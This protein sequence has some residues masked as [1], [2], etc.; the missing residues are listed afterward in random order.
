MVALLA[1]LHQ[2]YVFNGKCLRLPKKL[3]NRMQKNGGPDGKKCQLL[4][5]HS[6]SRLE[7]D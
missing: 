3:K 7:Q 6:V 5:L 2:S 1:F 4:I